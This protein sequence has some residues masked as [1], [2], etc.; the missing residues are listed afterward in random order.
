VMPP[1]ER[2]MKACHLDQFIKEF[3][4]IIQS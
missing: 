1:D 4:K 2:L 3:L